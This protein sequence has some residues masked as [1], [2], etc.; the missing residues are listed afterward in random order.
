MPFTCCLHEWLQVRQEQSSCVTCAH[1]TNVKFFFLEKLTNRVCASG[2]DTFFSSSNCISVQVLF[3]VAGQNKRSMFLGHWGVVGGWNLSSVNVRLWRSM[4]F[5]ASISTGL[6]TWSYFLVLFHFTAICIKKLCYTLHASIQIQLVALQVQLYE[7][8][9]TTVLTAANFVL[10]S[11]CTFHQM[12]QKKSLVWTFSPSTPSGPQ[13]FLSMCCF[14]MMQLLFNE[15]HKVFF[16]FTLL[17]EYITTV[18]WFKC[19]FVQYAGNKSVQKSCSQQKLSKPSTGTCVPLKSVNTSCVELLFFFVWCECPWQ[20]KHKLCTAMLKF[21]WVQMR[22]PK[23]RCSLKTPYFLCSLFVLPLYRWKSLIEFFPYVHSVRSPHLV[24]VVSR[25]SKI[26]SCSYA[27][28]GVLR[29]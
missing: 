1:L 7:K 29:T 24:N 27:C 5:R 28:V 22:K 19:C 16:F 21:F 6:L 3:Q 20:T 9:R 23:L 8:S 26:F 4:Y 18:G 14:F 2:T 11:V 13:L 12:W 25:C 15:L 10:C 17:V